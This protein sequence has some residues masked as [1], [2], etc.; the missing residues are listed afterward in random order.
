MRDR[1]CECCADGGFGT[2]DDQLLAGTGDGGVEQLSSQDAGAR[3]WEQHG[4]SIDLGA[5][6]L[7]DGQ[8]V[9]GLDG[10]QPS[11]ADLDESA[12]T[13]EDGALAASFACNDDASI[14]VEESQAVVVLRHK[15]WPADVPSVLG[16]VVEFAGEPA[17]DDGVPGGHAGCASSVGAEEAEGA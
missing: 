9:E 2:T 17:F 1:A 7:V 3:V 4:D 13:L 12:L 11:R 16:E 15:Q 14:A 5:L 10:G 6:A 8:R